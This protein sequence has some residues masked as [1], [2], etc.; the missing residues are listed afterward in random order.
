MSQTTP[1][2]T[3]SPSLV[4]SLGL[5]TAIRLFVNT[6]R[7]FAYP[8]ATVLAR[9]LGVPLPAIT[10][11]IAVNQLTGL[12]GPFLGPLSDRW[13]YRT[14]MLL[15]LGL[16]AGG[17]GAGALWPRYELIAG[18]LLLAG[19]AKIGFDPALQAYLGE[20]VPYARRGLAV[21][22]TELAW[23]G[24]TLLG[25]P[26]IG[27]LIARWD[28]RAPFYLLSGVGGVGLLVLGR[29]LPPEQRAPTD[30]RPPL[31]LLAAWR[32]LRTS[33]TAGR[34]L[35]FVFLAALAND[36]LF[37]VYGPWLEQRFAL[38]PTALGL[39]TA[40]IGGAELLGEGTTAALADRLGLSRAV[41]G[42]GLGV[43]LSYLLL[44]SLGQ[45]LPLALSG[46]FLVFLTFEFMMVATISWLTELLPAARATLLATALA[47]AG[48][49]RVVGSL[50]GGPLWLSGGLGA[51]GW[52]AAALSGLGLLS[53]LWG[54]ERKAGS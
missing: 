29:L 3:P 38:N 16:L 37:V 9:S 28:W 6:S 17:M 12:L 53:L 31:N 46:L 5:I 33:Q 7:R 30:R 39:S 24:S 14:V 21:G 52:L 23:A 15:S 36:L 13:G 40:I 10:S 47:A 45:S 43:T 11:L 18:A 35:L 8:F 32:L 22:L 41:V 20:R 27:L 49:G 50:L 48:L 19:L 25:V 34:A 1:R 44:P 4:L 42:G 26:L 54:R 2:P 51:T